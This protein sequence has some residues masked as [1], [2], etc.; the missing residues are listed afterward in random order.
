MSKRIVRIASV[1]APFGQTKRCG[2]IVIE[3]RA[4]LT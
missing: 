2:D 4:T 1:D 3:R